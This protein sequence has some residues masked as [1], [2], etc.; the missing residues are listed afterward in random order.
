M[1]TFAVFIYIKKCSSKQL[2]VGFDNEPQLLFTG[3]LIVNFHKNKKLGH[4]KYGQ[5]S[6]KNNMHKVFFFEVFLA[7]FA[8]YKTLKSSMCSEKFHNHGKV[9]SAC[10]NFISMEKV[11]KHR[12][13]ILKLI[14]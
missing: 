9:L 12:K 4:K 1:D 13:S 10:K 8:T 2:L 11:S 6:E 14:F 3:F 7:K 5:I